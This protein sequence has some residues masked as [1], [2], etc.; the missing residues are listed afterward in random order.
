MEEAGALGARSA[1]SHFA[2]KSEEEHCRHADS[3]LFVALALFRETASVAL[4]EE[5]L[6]SISV[7]QRTRTC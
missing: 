2:R 7:S 4:V 1:G 5:Q 6:L 3:R